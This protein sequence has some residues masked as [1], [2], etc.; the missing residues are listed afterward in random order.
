M[1]DGAVMTESVRLLLDLFGTVPHVM[2]C[3]K[4]ADGVYIGANRAFV[5]R[6]RRHH[7]HQVIGR[8]AGDLFP[9][10]LAASYEA[11]DRALLAT[12]QAVRNQLEL[13]ADA[14]HPGDGR[15]YLTTKVRHDRAAGGPVVVATSVDAQLGD[16]A[17]AATGLRAAIEIVHDRWDEALRVDDLAAAAG[18][19]TDRLER[20]MRRALAIS[21]K[22]YILRMRAERAAAL[23]AT[24]RLPIAQVAAEC[25]YYDQSQMTRQFRSHIGVT[26]SSYRHAVSDEQ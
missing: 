21:P 22:Q 1:T 2:I 20:A 26:P 5:R 18:M 14:D 6:T 23:L 19:S 10:A 15:W 13:I 24:T 11:Q 8:R 17:G 3:V 25:G 12:G 4:D 7:A 9:A 16:R